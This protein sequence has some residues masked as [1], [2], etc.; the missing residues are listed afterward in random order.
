MNYYTLYR[1]DCAC[2]ERFAGLADIEFYDIF[3]QV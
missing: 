1:L 2:A 3:G